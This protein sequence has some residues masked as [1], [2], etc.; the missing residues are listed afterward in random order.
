MNREWTRMNANPERIILKT[1]MKTADGADGA[2]IQIL[3][4]PQRAIR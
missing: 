3:A 1:A 4:A 2:D